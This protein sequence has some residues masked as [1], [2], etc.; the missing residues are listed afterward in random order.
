MKIYRAFYDSWRFSFEAFGKTEDEAKKLMIKGLKK[1]TKH[2]E[3]PNNDWWY[4]D[5]IGVYEVEIG[6]S[7]CD[8][9]EL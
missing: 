8:C 9:S 5:D 1:H 6:K 3:L 4:E 2:Y 7:Y